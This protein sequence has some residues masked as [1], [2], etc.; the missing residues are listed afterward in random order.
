M[1]IQTLSIVIGSRACNARCPFCVSRMTGFGE[2]SPK[3]QAI[4]WLN[5]HKACGL[6][7]G[8]GTNTV[9][10][11]GKGEPTLF[12][13]EIGA[14]LNPL[15]AF[16]FPLVELQTNGLEI[17][18][19]ARDGASKVPGLDREV[20]VRWHDAGLNTIAIS[21]VGTSSKAN[22]K[23]YDRDYPELEDTVRFLHGIGYTVRLCVMMLKGFVDTPARAAEMIA[24]CRA[25]GID[26]LTMR[27]IRKPELARDL[28]AGTFVKDYCLTDEQEK[29][30]AEF[31]EKH[32]TRLMSL[33]HGAM[34]YDVEGQNVCLS[35]CL[36]VSGVNDD[37]RT[38]IFYSDGRLAYDWQYGGAVIL[39][40]RPGR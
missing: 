11:T 28:V 40:G 32:G 35:D 27:P 6:A 29:A 22:A 16:D 3:A 9:L 34:V 8:G 23:I 13:N 20:L 31:V 38:L 14:Y 26:Q 18:R 15:G 10:L 37:I 19:L 12:P 17:G 21:A 39:A 5:F 33:M 7:K 24:E 25:L 36:T 1:R 30:I 2:L 4:N